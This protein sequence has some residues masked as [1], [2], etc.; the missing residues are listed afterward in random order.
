M[1]LVDYTIGHSLWFFDEKDWTTI[2]HLLVWDDGR[3]CGYDAN[4]GIWLLA[5]NIV[6]FSPLVRSHSEWIASLCCNNPG[7][8]S[9]NPRVRYSPPSEIQTRNHC[10]DHYD[11]SSGVFLDRNCWVRQEFLTREKREL[12]E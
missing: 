5:W 6:E 9:L 2:L 1:D 10:S 3:V 4:A 7:A 12:L 8:L 11:L